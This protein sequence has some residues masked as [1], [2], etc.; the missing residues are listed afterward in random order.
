MQQ[1][2]KN[3]L[4]TSQRQINIFAHNNIKK[5]QN[6]WKQ[7]KYNNMKRLQH[8]FLILLLAMPL[9]AFAQGWPSNYGGVM[10][11]SFYWDS[12]NDTQ[13]SNLTSQADTLSKY[14]NLIWVPQSGWC[15]G[16]T[17]MGYADIYWLDQHSAFGTEAE[18]KKMIST[19]KKKGLSTIAD[20]VI[21]HKNGKS[22]W[23]DFPNE[24]YTNSTTGKT[25]KLTWANPLED[26]CTG[27][28]GGKTQKAGYNV[29]GAA[30]TGDDFDG[31]R[32]LD[33][34]NTE[35]QNN[36]KTYLDF[37]LS[38]MG[39]S[40]FR[41]DM[42]G[43]YS[44]TYT[45][46]YNESAKPS[47]SVGEYWRSD[48]LSGLQNWVN[49]TGKTSAAFDFQLKW[50][51][52]NA[53]NNSSWS[54]LANYTAQSLIGSGYAQYAVTF[55]DNHDTYRDNNML[56]KNI[57]AANAYLLTMPGTPCVFL[58][59]Y[60]AYTKA[61]KKFILARKLVGITNEST[62][63]VNNGET[64]GY[65]VAVKGANDNSMLLCL[66]TTTTSTSG[67]QLVASGDNYKLYVSNGLD[68]S[69]IKAIDGS[70][71]ET[72]T[73]PSCATVVNDA[74]YYAYFEKP[75]NWKTTIY[76][77]AWEDGGKNLYSSWPGSKAEVTPVGTNSKTGNSVYLWKYTGTTT[78]NVNKIIFNDGTSKTG[79]LD[80]KNG[81]YYTFYGSIGNVSSAT[82]IRTINASTTASYASWYTLS[83]VRLSKEPTEKGVYIHEGK[84]VIK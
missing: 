17:Q 42:T 61:I 5:E 32:D 40:G 41:Y 68:I 18:L 43:G 14:F 37:L 39:Y 38:E 34:T 2:N 55:T 48:G 77:W 80:F 72:N 52:N 63:T 76:V 70:K 84:K 57:E 26:I 31:A 65:S 11:Q 1:S 47:F 24:T 29:S 71:E 27:D 6:I 73:L 82:A 33:H 66:G 51:I 25:Y 58:P 64:N 22:T 67:Y 13:W 81:N 7:I 59:H 36:I 30:D 69:G 60:Q 9:G 23:V 74:T 53:F 16:M 44:P 3:F 50:L 62:V 28:D 75:S 54:S 20:V 56:K 45:K 21:N 15:N 12:Y 46:M 78:V 83:G 49:N 10:L 19:F 35:V 8:L 79:D 4:V